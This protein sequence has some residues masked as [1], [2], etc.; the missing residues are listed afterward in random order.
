VI[1]EFLA[2]ILAD[3]AVFG[4]IHSIVEMLDQSALSAH[5]EE[6]HKFRMDWLK[7]YMKQKKLKPEL[8]QVQCWMY[9]LSNTNQSKKDE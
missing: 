5:A 9:F 6:Q 4:N 2:G 8:Q 7:S 3:G 1:I